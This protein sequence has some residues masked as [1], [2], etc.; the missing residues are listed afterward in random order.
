MGK[1][2]LH[3]SHCTSCCCSAPSPGSLTTLRHLH[4]C[5]GDGSSSFFTF[6]THLPFQ[7]THW[8]V[9]Y[10]TGDRKT[11]VLR[12]MIN[13]CV[14]DFWCHPRLFASDYICVSMWH[15]AWCYQ[16]PWPG[17]KL[18]CAFVFLPALKIFF[19]F[20]VSV[21]CFTSLDFC[22]VVYREIQLRIMFPKSGCVLQSSEMHKIPMPMSYTQ[23]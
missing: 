14:Y 10:W 8:K 22:D 9:F 19:F 18:C 16:E 5:C 23:N 3:L 2:Q 6:P 1:R 7:N 12:E 20:W 21:G 15:I 4:I 17:N 13:Y 11:K